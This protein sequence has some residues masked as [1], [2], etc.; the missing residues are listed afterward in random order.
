MRT[1]KK[2]PQK[3][4]KKTPSRVHK[5]GVVGYS[6]KTALL[7]EAITHMNTGKY[8]RSSAALKDL[9]SLDPHNTEARRLFATL[10]LRLG[11]LATARQ[12]FES[13]ANEAI[14]RQDFWLAES[15]LR[16]YLAA[17][18]RCVPFLEL[19][20]HVYEE[21]GDALAAVAELGKAI[22]ILI[23]GPDSENPKKPS[24][25]Y[26]KVRELAPASSVAFQFASLFDIQTGELLV[27]HPLAP[28]AVTSLEID[29]SQPQDKILATTEESRAS[30]V[31]P[32]EQFDGAPP[33]HET[34]P[35]TSSN[36]VIELLDVPDVLIDPAP[37]GLAPQE[38]D[39]PPSESA[40][41]I[42]EAN[43][44]D[45]DLVPSMLAEPPLPSKG[46]RDDGMGDPI[47]EP[48]S[49][50]GEGLSPSSSEERTTDV[51]R[52]I[53]SFVGSQ[54]LSSPMPWEQIEN[55]TIRIE[56]A[57]PSSTPLAQSEGTPLLGSESVLAPS[58][59]TQPEFV[60]DQL[61]SPAPA[62]DLTEPSESIFAVA[63][64]TSPA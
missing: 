35:P 39:V 58:A 25:L 36:P 51:G 43:R 16:E 46:H 9:L 2:H 26:A 18:P 17:G 20:A 44:L 41:L 40:G 30:D 29:A 32:W 38:L 52:G 47:V 21:K 48:S 23:E 14:G 37:V 34:P 5:R 1:D 24:Q 7:E 62:P 28:A 3:A 56:E 49:F 19:L 13:L 64:S 8:G 45:P 61:S 10:H 4:D 59:T 54:G 15:L 50:E 12:A 60:S 31:M 63:P 55:S 22:D 27:P 57:A 53:T 42:Q 33:S 11:S 6:K